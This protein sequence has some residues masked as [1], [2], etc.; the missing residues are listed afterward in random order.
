[1]VTVSL[2]DTHPQDVKFESCIRFGKA[3][4]FTQ[5]GHCGAD[6]R[7]VVIPDEPGKYAFD[8]LTCGK[9]SGDAHFDCPCEY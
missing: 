3:G 6:M 8:C 5:C 7:G 2:K 9:N 1:M 4:V